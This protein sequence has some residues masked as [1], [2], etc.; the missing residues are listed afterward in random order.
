MSNRLEDDSDVTLRPSRAEGSG[1]GL[2]PQAPDSES[3]PGRTQN[4][5]LE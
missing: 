5:I 1:V 3:F 2:P 4:D